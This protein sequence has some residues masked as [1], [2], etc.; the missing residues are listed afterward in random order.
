M[1]GEN[2]VHYW[3]T[4]Y[5]QPF[6]DNTTKRDITATVGQPALLHCRV[7]NLGDRAVGISFCLNFKLRR[8]LLRSSVLCISNA[9]F[10]CR[11]LAMLTNIHISINSCVKFV[12]Y[13]YGDY[14]LRI[15]AFTDDDFF[16]SADPYIFPT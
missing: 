9:Y 15:T 7:R 6:F 10:F 8:F 2:G 5:A 14:F 11:L 16:F 12:F 4:P 1:C 3:D 13:S